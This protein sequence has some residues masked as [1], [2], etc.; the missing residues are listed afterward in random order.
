MRWGITDD[1]VEQQLV[2]KICLY[3]IEKCQKES[4]GPSFVVSIV[5]W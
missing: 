5:S 2:T 3:E 4:I 1:A